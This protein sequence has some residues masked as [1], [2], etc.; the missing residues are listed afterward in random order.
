[1]SKESKERYRLAAS[2]TWAARELMC[3]S[4]PHTF[5]DEA[6][7]KFEAAE[8][9]MNA[10][11]SHMYAY[12]YNPVVLEAKTRGDYSVFA[13]QLRGPN[14]KKIRS[15]RGWS[16]KE[17]KKAL[18][19]IDGLAEE[20]RLEYESRHEP[21]VHVWESEGGSGEVKCACGATGGPA[22]NDRG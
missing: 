21:G 17:V 9:A 12:K 4:M 13:A 18:P 10:Y 20:S 6:W 7:E 19:I 22:H 16:K 11:A 2:F 1:M 15:S 5:D 8:H 14:I 3:R